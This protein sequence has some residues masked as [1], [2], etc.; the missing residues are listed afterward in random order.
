ME[1]TLVP[2]W[3]A[4]NHSKTSS[5]D[6]N[7]NKGP[8]YAEDVLTRTYHAGL[9]S[10]S[11]MV[12]IVAA[13][14]T[15]PATQMVLNTFHH[16]GTGDGAAEEYLVACESTTPESDAHHEYLLERS[17]NKTA[18]TAKIIRDKL[19]ATYVKDLVHRFSIRRRRF[20]V[21]NLQRMP[22]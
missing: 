21:R 20:H 16:T 19:H 17:L 3:L 4:P 6:T 9:A 5:S 11:D 14:S 10:P 2:P 18:E 13:Q 7:I 22:E 15:E 1:W 12:G 8:A